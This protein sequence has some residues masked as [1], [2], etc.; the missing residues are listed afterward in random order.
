MC[1]SVVI[2]YLR[3]CRPSLFTYP[4]VAEVVDETFEMLTL[5]NLVDHRQTQGHCLRSAGVVGI[6]KS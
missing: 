3:L 2:Y 1:D 6:W 4:L 5:L